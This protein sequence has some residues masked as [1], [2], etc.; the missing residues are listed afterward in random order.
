[1]D[2]YYKLDK[3]KNSIPC[4]MIEWAEQRA[5][6]RKTN[7]KHVNDENVYGHRVSTVWLGLNHNLDGII[8]PLLFETMV[9]EGESM[10]EIYCK[11]YPTWEMAEEGHKQAVEWVKNGCKEDES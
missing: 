9:F 4:E 6:M 10:M 2:M 3:N 8:P 1:M 11:L 7:T 5:E